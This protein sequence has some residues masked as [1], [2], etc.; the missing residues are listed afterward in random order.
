MSLSIQQTPRASRWAW[1]AVLLFCRRRAA[2][3]A[4]HIDAHNPVLQSVPI[5][6]CNSEFEALT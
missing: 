2:I 1:Q 5:K 6:D 3:L 4:R